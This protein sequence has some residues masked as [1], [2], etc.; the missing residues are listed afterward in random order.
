MVQCL[1]IF[2]SQLLTKFK[3]LFERIFFF[4]NYHKLHLFRT[5]V[6]RSLLA[7]FQVPNLCTK[8]ADLVRYFFQKLIFFCVMP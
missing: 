1:V 8:V 3:S 5:P 2:N 6:H 7:F 4:A